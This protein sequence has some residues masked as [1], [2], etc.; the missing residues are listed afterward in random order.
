MVHHAVAALTITVLLAATPAALQA[1]GSAAPA[2][3]AVTPQLIEAGAKLFRG[4]GLCAACHGADAKGGVAPSLVDTVW[5]HGKGTYEEI[6]ARVMA[7][8]P[9]DSSV[10]GVT[11]PPRGGTRISDEQVRAVAAYVWSLSR[12]AKP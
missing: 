1:Q 3:T 4:E 12:P 9:V 2:P 6:V 7:G 5:L 11:M 10:S 8:V